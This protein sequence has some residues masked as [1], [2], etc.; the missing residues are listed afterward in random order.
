MLYVAKDLDPTA[1][2]IFQSNKFFSPE[3]MKVMEYFSRNPFIDKLQMVHVVTDQ[4]RELVWSAKDG[5][6]AQPFADLVCW[7]IR[8]IDASQ[9]VNPEFIDQAIQDNLSVHQAVESWF[10][11]TDISVAVEH[12]ASG[13]SGMIDVDIEGV[14]SSRRAVFR[15]DIGQGE[16]FNFYYGS[17]SKG[18]ATWS[19]DLKTSL[20][21]YLNS[22]EE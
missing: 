8:L 2:Y 19:K 22:I 17:S 10:D 16:L 20:H 1:S 7:Y 11:G 18:G 9:E 3:P 4:G 6:S 15:A 13:S 14:G 12:H 5:W 21:N